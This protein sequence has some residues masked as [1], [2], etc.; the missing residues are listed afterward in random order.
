MARARE[1]LLVPVSV[2]SHRRRTRARAR[3]VRDT[4][5]APCLLGSYVREAIRR[6]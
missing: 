3:R 1:R 4:A 2:G 6:S 5:C